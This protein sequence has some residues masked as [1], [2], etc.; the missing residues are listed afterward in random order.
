MPVD[1]VVIGSG[2]TA[3]SLVRTLLR[4]SP[5]LAVVIIEARSLCS[6]A[7]GRNGGHCKTMTFASWED[8]KQRFGIREACRI[9]ELEHAHLDAMADAIHED[10]VACDLVMTEGV[11]AYFDKASFDR[12]VKALEDMKAYVP[13]IAAKHKVYSDKEYIQKTLKLSKSCVGAITIPAASLWP[14]K[15]VTGVLGR[16]AE[17]GKLN[18]QTHTPVLNIIDD[19]SA[20][21]ALVKTSRGGITTKAVVHATNAWLGHLL[22]ELRPFVSPVRGNVVRYDALDSHFQSGEGPKSVLGFDSRFSLWLRYGDK[23]YDYLIQRKAGDIVV[24]RANMGRK[25]TGNDGH[26]DEAAM[27]HLRRLGDVVTASPAPGASAHITHAW[28]GIL[29]FTEDTLPFAG[30]LPFPQRSHQWVCGG[31]HATGMIKAFLT[32]QAVAD[33]LLGH[34]PPSKFP[35]STMVTE[36][37]I[38]ALRKSLSS[39]TKPSFAPSAPSKL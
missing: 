35:Q 23:D 10:G 5:N 14:Y 21:T 30:R 8:R 36:E 39:E 25:T 2:I 33:M 20:S 3:M 13:Q 28:S 16:L 27:A 32:A 24:G 9:T 26:T 29:A 22:P 11:D 12:A 7:T 38:E 37:R 18:I 19:I 1:V 31:Y 34:Q 15:W 4:K 6:G 17:S